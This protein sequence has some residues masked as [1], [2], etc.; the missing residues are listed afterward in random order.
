MTHYVALLH[1]IVLSPGQRV[2][3]EKLRVTAE[4]V[5]CRSVRTLVSTGNLVFEA[6]DTSVS[7][8]ES[9]LEAGFARDFG[10]AVDIIARTAET[11]RAL[12]AGNPFPETRETNGA[13]IG[14]RVMRQPL[15]PSTIDKLARY[16]TAGERIALVNG[17]LWMDFAAK[18]GAS[19]LLPALTTKRLGIGTIRN[20]N[21]VRNLATMLDAG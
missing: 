1:S 5:G 16:C 9:R 11:W 13:N 7:D 12:T 3:M 14:V 19:K 8:I 10:K 21:T 15:E 4:S 6:D 17:D 18:P 2:V 20:W